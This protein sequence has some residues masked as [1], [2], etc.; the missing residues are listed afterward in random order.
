MKKVMNFSTIY[1]YFAKLKPSID[2]TLQQINYNHFHFVSFYSNP[3]EN[4]DKM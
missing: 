4:H 3:S 2:Y 1:K